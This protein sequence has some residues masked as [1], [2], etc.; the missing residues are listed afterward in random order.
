MGVEQ[1]RLKQLTKVIKKVR[2]QRDTMVR[3][4]HSTLSLLARTLEPGRQPSKALLKQTKVEAVE[5]F[6]RLKAA[7][8]AHIDMVYE[9]PGYGGRM[10]R[11]DS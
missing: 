10:A 4:Q 2:H 11:N 1:I 3:T 9:G 8:N 7:R 5:Q 6:Q